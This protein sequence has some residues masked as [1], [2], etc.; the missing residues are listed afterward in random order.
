MLAFCIQRYFLW[1]DSWKINAFDCLF[2]IF[3]LPDFY[4]NLFFLINFTFILS[5]HTL[6][7]WVVYIA[8]LFTATFK[9][10][11]SKKWEKNLVVFLQCKFYNKDA[12]MLL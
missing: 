6:N 4:I 5:F 12:G 7:V 1:K 3:T 2:T 9:L 11:I 10:E 8:Y